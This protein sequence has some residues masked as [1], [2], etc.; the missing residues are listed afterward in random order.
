MSR[1][2]MATLLALL[3]SGCAS[4]S[5]RMVGAMWCAE[6]TP[7]SPGCDVGVGTALAAHDRVSWVATIGVET[8]G[9]GVAWTANPSG[10][11]IVAVGV[12]A[13]ARW[14][15]SGVES[16]VYPAIGATVSFGG[17]E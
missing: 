2:T 7:G 16:E 5:G 17:R 12:G 1:I 15:E 3:L 13:V 6:D 14:S 9:T 4:T 10:R 8:I 11:P